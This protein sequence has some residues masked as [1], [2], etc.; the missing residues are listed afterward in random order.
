[1]MLT[2]GELKRLAG[3][4][5]DDGIVDASLWHEPHVSRYGGTVSIR[6]VER[7][8]N[9]LWFHCEDHHWNDPP[10][11]H[12]YDPNLKPFREHEERMA[13]DVPMDRT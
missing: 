12:S 7:Q 5:P 8:G 4:L 9:T 2:W 13:K 3:D 10:E 11:S 1:M 6:A